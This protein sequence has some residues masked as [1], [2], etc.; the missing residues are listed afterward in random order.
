[1]WLRAKGVACHL[2]CCMT[3]IEYQCTSEAW[4]RQIVSNREMA[5]AS[6]KTAVGGVSVTYRDKRGHTKQH[7]EY[8]SP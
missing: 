1:M 7:N 8:I 6:V 3:W 2:S 4:L 5:Q